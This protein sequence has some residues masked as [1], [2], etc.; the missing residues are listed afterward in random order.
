MLHVHLI[1]LGLLHV[2]LI[3]LLEHIKH[4]SYRTSI[5]IGYLLQDLRSCT[6]VG[7]DLS[8]PGALLLHVAHNLP[9]RIAH[10]PLPLPQD[11]KL[12]IALLP[13]LKRI[14]ALYL[15]DVL[16][17]VIVYDLLSRSDRWCYAWGS[18]GCLA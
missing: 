7:N 14:I 12:S 3:E 17:V 2:L 18:L 5:Y 10:H 11:S 15:L 1:K 6:E 4:L 9:N 8:N 16:C 13:L